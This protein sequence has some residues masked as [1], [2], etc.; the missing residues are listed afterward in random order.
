[1]QTTNGAFR[2]EQAN[3]DLVREK[4]CFKL[5][6]NLQAMCLKMSDDFQPYKDELLKLEKQA[7]KEYG[8]LN[9]KRTNK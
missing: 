2:F 7:R 8:R 4:Q 9:S 6:E 1:M 5:A 3:P